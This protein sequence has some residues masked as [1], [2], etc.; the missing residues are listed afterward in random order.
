MGKTRADSRAL[1]TDFTGRETEL[2]E[3]DGFLGQGGPTRIVVIEGTAGSERPLSPSIG[4]IDCGK[5]S[6]TDNSS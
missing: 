6:P 4:R 1:V 2:A 5:N 3:L